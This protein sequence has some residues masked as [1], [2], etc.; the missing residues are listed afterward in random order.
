MCYMTR[1]EQVGVRELRQNLSVYVQRVKRGETLVVTERGKPVARLMPAVGDSVLD[2][3]I[4][5]GQV[6]PA[7]RDWEGLPP[8]LPRRPDE[9]TLTEVLLG[10]R[11]EE[12]R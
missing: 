2:R 8:P 7:T 4:A 6:R 3:M 12:D 10:M 5:D 11:D 9:P 1:P